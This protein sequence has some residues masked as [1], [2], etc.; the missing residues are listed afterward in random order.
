VQGLLEYKIQK[1]ID[2][3]DDEYINLTK[4]LGDIRS[5][6]NGGKEQMQYV[7][8]EYFQDIVQSYIMDGERH[9][10]VSAKIYLKNGKIK[11]SQKSRGRQTPYG[12][13]F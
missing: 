7:F 4:L 5:S 8:N 13:V 10:N 1:K 6:Y 11:V 9:I 12:S 2:I 3:K